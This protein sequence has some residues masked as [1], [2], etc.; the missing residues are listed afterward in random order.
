SSCW[1]RSRKREHRH[2]KREP[3]LFRPRAG[4]ASVFLPRHHHPLQ[5]WPRTIA[6]TPFVENRDPETAPAIAP[7]ASQP[8]L[9]I[10]DERIRQN[11]MPPLQ[12]SRR[13]LHAALA[14]TTHHDH[15]MR[16]EIAE[17]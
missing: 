7:L 1:L 6:A 8:K 4:H 11:A 3:D 5:P 9:Q 10:K 13:K 17:A 12:K 16:G 2:N 14:G 15:F